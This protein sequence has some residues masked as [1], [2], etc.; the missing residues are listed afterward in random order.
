MLKFSQRANRGDHITREISRVLAHGETHF[1]EY[2][3]FESPIHGVCLSLDGDIQSCTSDEALYHEALA[4]P[5]MLMHPHPKTVLIMGGSEGSTAREVLRHPGV[6]KVVMIE[7][8]QDLVELCKTWIPSWGERAFNDPRLEV[9]CQDINVYLNDNDTRFD[10]VIGDLIDVHD[11]DEPVANLYGKEFYSRLK[12]HLN[13]NAIVATQGGALVP[14]DME[15]H[16][17][18]RNKV[19]CCFEHVY[20]YG[21]NIPSFY[22]LWGFILASDSDLEIKAEK[23]LERF[24][25]TAKQRELDIPASGILGLAAAFS[26][27]SVIHRQFKIWED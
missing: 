9:V 7:I 24:S 25:A 10:I 23:M 1:H 27:P 17:K 4:H 21:M 11:W 5:A 22:H 20:S 16:L 26:L 14:N 13:P 19:K 6:E 15:G 18:I 12:E 2:F 3:F 8:D